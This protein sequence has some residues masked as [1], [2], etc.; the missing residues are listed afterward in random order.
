MFGS[1]F[2]GNNAPLA[3]APLGELRAYWE[4]L[5]VD[6]AI[7]QRAAVDPR[8]IAGALECAF[9]LERIAPGQARFR[10]G[11]MHLAELMGMEVRGMPVM[12]LIAPQDRAAFATALE[13]VFSGPAM[14]EMWLE[15]ERGPGRPALE[16]R[17]LILPLADEAG[18]A[19][20]AVGVLVTAGSIGRH[21][22]RFALARRTVTRVIVPA[23]APVF[24]EVPVAYAPPPRAAPGRAHLRLVASD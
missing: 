19:T 4:G 21:G 15:G 2:G 17:L 3:T 6:G 9:L 7:P 10:L 16:G 8:G 18:A 22:R 5:R 23:Q 11:G 14:V 12:S 24:A 13:Q 20:R 1:I